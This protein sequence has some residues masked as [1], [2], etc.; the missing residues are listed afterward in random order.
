MQNHPFVDGNKRT[1]HAAMEVFLVLN[2]YEICAA[3]DGQQQII[4][5]VAAGEIERDAFTIW[6]QN[7]IE[8]K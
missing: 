8:P 4:L 6:L 3:V 5:Q 7:H 2:G 1:A